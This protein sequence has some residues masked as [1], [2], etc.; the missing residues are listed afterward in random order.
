MIFKNSDLFDRAQTLNHLWDTPH[1]LNPLSEVESVEIFWRNPNL[2]FK[3]MDPS[4]GTQALNHFWGPS[5][6][7]HLPSEFEKVGTTWRNPNVIFPISS[8]KGHKI[9]K[10]ILACWKTWITLTKLKP[11]TTFKTWNILWD[12]PEAFFI[13]LKYHQGLEKSRTHEKF[14]TWF[15]LRFETS[16]ETSNLPWDLKP[17]GNPFARLETIITG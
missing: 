13:F 17:F 10:N 8:L 4:E 14:Q 11:W 15:R 3:N 6:A 12:N 9:L 2:I 16:F 7:L 5:H 1:T